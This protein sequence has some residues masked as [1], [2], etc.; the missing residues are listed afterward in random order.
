MIADDP[1]QFAN[2]VIEIYND[3]SRWVRMSRASLSHVEKN[4]SPSIATAFFHRLLG[5][6]SPNH[7]T[8]RTLVTP[9]S[10]EE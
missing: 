7:K 4:Y 1:L 8:T 10:T 2:K 3:K 9:G 5:D 6:I